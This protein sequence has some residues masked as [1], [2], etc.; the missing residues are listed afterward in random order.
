M[1]IGDWEPHAVM[2]QAARR[3]QESFT[4]DHRSNGSG[5]DKAVS[6]IEGLGAP[7]DWASIKALKIPGGFIVSLK[8]FGEVRQ[9]L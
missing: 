6:V 5:P 8:P 2:K 4:K 9:D 7:A 3:W 1:G